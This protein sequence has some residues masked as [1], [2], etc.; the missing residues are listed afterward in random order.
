ME[1]RA[2][3]LQRTWTNKGKREIKASEVLDAIADWHQE[4][5]AS[6]TAAMAQVQFL[7]SKP[8]E[9]CA[10]LG[11]SRIDLEEHALGVVDALLA[12]DPQSADAWMVRFS[13]NRLR[14]SQTIAVLDSHKHQADRLDRDLERA[15]ELSPRHAAANLAAAESTCPVA[16]ARRIGFPRD[17]APP[18][19]ETLKAAQAHLLVA[20]QAAPREES[21]Y[22]GLAELGA[23]GGDLRGVGCVLELATQQ[24]PA[25]SPTLFLRRAEHAV[26]TEDWHACDRWLAEAERSLS[27][28]AALEVD[29]R[30]TANRRD[31]QAIAELLR[32]TRLQRDDSLADGR[33]RSLETLERVVQMG[34]DDVI[35]NLAY[36]LLAERYAD[37]G[38]HIDARAALRRAQ[39]ADAVKSM[40][41]G[42]AN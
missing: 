20:Q 35:E 34:A 21:A 8:D 5:P 9:N 14:K 31:W 6:V 2:R 17:A 15:L 29:P 27:R 7:F 3:A 18:P 12:A 26:E 10:Q 37:V 4:N 41:D 39:R 11:W 22:L 24:I 25:P 32:A 28:L 16:F 23:L 36:G 40:R 30:V 38:R 13:V 19:I 1:L 42:L 33:H